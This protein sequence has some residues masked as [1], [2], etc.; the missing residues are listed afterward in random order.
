MRSRAATSRRSSPRRIPWWPCGAL[1]VSSLRT[2]RSG[3]SCDSSTLP[4]VAALLRFREG[5]GVDDEDRSVVVENEDHLNQIACRTS[6]PDQE[7]FVADRPRI[8]CS[9]LAND[10]LGVRRFDPVSC[11]VLDHLARPVSG[12]LHSR[13]VR[14]APL[15]NLARLVVGLLCRPARRVPEGP[16]A[17]L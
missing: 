4:P 7:P 13:R 11:D 17:L 3:S 15:V 12:M 16:L 6:T 8:R 14:G 10:L 1:R 2:S 5:P 9:R